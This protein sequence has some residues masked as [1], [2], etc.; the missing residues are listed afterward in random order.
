MANI[1][2]RF[3]GQ[4]AAPSAGVW[5]PFRAMR[6]ALRWDPFREVESAFGGDYQ[7]FAPRFDV[8][9]TKEAYVFQADVPGVKENDLEISLTGNHLAISGHREQEKREQNEAFYAAE[10]T[11]GSFTRT[12]TLP[13]GADAENVRAE[14]KNGVLALTIPKK[15]E[16]QPRKITIGTGEA[17][18]KAKA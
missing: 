15:P 4:E 9:E 7:A 5:D 11:Y 3:Q 1:I 12:F 13:D 8:K 17:G 2:R 16:I 14:L 6:D 18:G 10:R